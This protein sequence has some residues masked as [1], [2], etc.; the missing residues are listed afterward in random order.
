VETTYMLLLL[1]LR[2]Y[3]VLSELPSLGQ[4]WQ[5]FGRKMHMTE[6]TY[7]I[8]VLTTGPQTHSFTVNDI[9]ESKTLYQFARCHEL[10]LWYT[11]LVTAT[12]S[13]T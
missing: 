5:Q 13:G 3:H 10:T 1:H 12:T 2:G 6:V 11:V 9:F 4:M 8:I 7:F